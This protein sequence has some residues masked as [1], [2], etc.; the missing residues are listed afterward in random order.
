MN[1]TIEYLEKLRDLI[2]LHR[3]KLTEAIAGLMWKSYGRQVACITIDVETGDIYEHDMSVGA[4]WPDEVKIW[5]STG[6]E[7]ASPY[8]MWT[9]QDWTDAIA[10]AVGADYLPDVLDQIADEAGAESAADYVRNYEQYDK[11]DKIIQCCAPLRKI[12][13]MIEDDIKSDT[14]SD[15]RKAADM[16]IDHVIDD[17]ESYE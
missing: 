7:Y 17:L 6:Y 9:L 15:R 1:K 3:G 5:S 4:T 11:I 2:E 13:D 12:Y 8:E 14:D 16:V 10:Y